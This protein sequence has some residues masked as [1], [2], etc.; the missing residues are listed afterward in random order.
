M[1][2]PRTVLLRLLAE[3]FT[4]LAVLQLLVVAISISSVKAGWDCEAE[5]QHACCLMSC[6][7]LVKGR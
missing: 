5:Q 4:A 1:P 3:V 6:S 2:V 7:S